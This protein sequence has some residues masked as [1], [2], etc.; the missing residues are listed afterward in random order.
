MNNS[1]TISSLLVLSLL[2]VV[3]HA[4]GQQLT[5][6]SGL[7]N[8]EGVNNGQSVASVG[9]ALEQPVNDRLSVGIDLSFWGGQN[10]KLERVLASA[11]QLSEPAYYHGNHGLGLMGYFDLYESSSQPPTT[12]VYCRAAIPAPKANRNW[13]DS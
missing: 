11:G 2:L 4:S 12:R 10:G 9:I 5:L 8:M 6:F 1:G 13:F 3:Q 7:A